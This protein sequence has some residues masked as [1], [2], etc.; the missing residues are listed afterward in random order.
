MDELFANMSVGL[1][2]AGMNRRRFLGKVVGAAGIAAAISAVLVTGVSAN[3]C[4][5]S[6]FCETSRSTVP[7]YCGDS[8]CSFPKKPRMW[9]QEGN[10][11]YTGATC[12]TLYTFRDCNAS[13]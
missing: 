5:G 2:R 12:P 13:C 11:C 1:A 3:H 10:D 9:R 4:Q 7:G 8:R 6:H